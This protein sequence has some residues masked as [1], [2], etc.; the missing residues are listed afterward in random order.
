MPVTTTNQRSEP[1][2]LVIVIVLALAA[3]GATYYVMT[4]RPAPEQMV[5]VPERAPVVVAAGDVAPLPLFETF[6]DAQLFRAWLGKANETKPEVAVP[7]RTEQLGSGTAGAERL[8]LTGTTCSTRWLRR[9]A[10]GRPV[11]S[12]S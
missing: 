7:T 1:S 4:G 12:V 11:P 5:K 8:K 6:S 10:A 2:G 9:H 3:A